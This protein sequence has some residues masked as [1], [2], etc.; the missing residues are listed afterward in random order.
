MNYRGNR[1]LAADESFTHQIVETFA[2]VG[3]SDISWTEKVW[4]SVFSPDGGLQIDVG[5]GKYPNRNVMDGFG[6][7]SQGRQQWT[8]R[9][10]RE[11]SSEL[12]ATEVG[13]IRYEVL[14]PL[15]QVRF[16]LR[17]ND[18][19]PICFEITLTG[20]MRPVFEDRDRRWDST[21]LRVVTDVLRYHQPVQVEGW[22][23]VDG[24]RHDLAGGWVGFRDHSWGVRRNVGVDVPDLRR[25]SRPLAETTYLMHWAPFALQR[26]DGSHYELQY[27]LQQTA[28][29]TIYSS[30]YLYQP[31]GSQ[32]RA[33][34]ITPELRFDQGTRRVLG[35]RLVFDLES[36]EQR[37]LEVE[38]MSDTGFHLG[39]ALYM[40]FRGQHHG[41]WKGRFHL[42]G[43]HIADCTD[44]ALLPELH[45]LRD[46]IVR[47]R[48]GD[49]TGWGLIES[50]MTGAWPQYGLT[51]EGSFV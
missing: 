11:L 48:D 35:G 43:E 29:T 38:P 7:V 27:H 47:V 45:Q 5:L 20:L 3:E 28:R 19:V 36:G 16:S 32:I 50:I 26:P 22:V 30:G 40:D 33:W 51:A 10:S 42:D 1:L 25:P 44:P 8:V 34:R 15:E 37:A 13:P 2:T 4:A 12:E 49:A 18:V 6:G 23:E 41:S 9:A 14:Q 17:P 46:C 24:T 31:D 21:G 39:T